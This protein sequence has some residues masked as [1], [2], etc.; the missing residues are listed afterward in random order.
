MK[1]SARQIVLLFFLL[2]STGLWAQVGLREDVEYLSSPL[3]NG[4]VTGSTGAVEVSWY[5]LRRFRA[6]GLDTSIGTFRTSKGIGRNIVA[7]H[8]GNP[9]S[10]SYVLVMAYYD[11]MPPVKGE[12]LPGADANASGV[13]MLLS[14]ADSLANSGSN[15]IFAALDGH[16]AGR[17]GAEVLSRGPWKIS[18]VANIDTIGST[19]A[20]PS[21]FRPDFIIMLGGDDFEKKNSKALDK[22]NYGPRLRLYY[23]YYRSKAFTDYFYRS[24]SDQT[25]FLEKKIPAVM[26]TS[27]ITM[28]T[29]KPGDTFE[30][31]DYDVMERRRAF[32]LSWLKTL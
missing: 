14:L 31:L 10:S 25:P 24:A 22:L 30:T 9:K 15:Y 20:P 11:S 4:R 13:A 27:G 17:M 18:M 23:D 32:I 19:L 7:V 29:N 1:I 16:N 12:F 28:N 5:L 6:A 8:K 2:C 21:E 3:L 26:F